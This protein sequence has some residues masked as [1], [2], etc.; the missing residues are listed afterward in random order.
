M[1]PQNSNTIISDKKIDK[2]YLQEDDDDDIVLVSSTRERWEKLHG[3]EGSYKNE[4]EG[5]GVF[6]DAGDEDD[7]LVVALKPTPKRQGNAS[8]ND[9][10]E[11]S[12]FHPLFAF[13]C[14]VLSIW[15]ILRFWRG[16]R[17]APTTK[18]KAVTNA[19][20]T[21]LSTTTPIAIESEETAAD[22]TNNNTDREGG[23]AMKISSAQEKTKSPVL[24]TALPR[25]PVPKT[26]SSSNNQQ[27]TGSTVIEKRNETRALAQQFARDV[28]L[29]QEVLA[30]HSLDPSIAPQLAMSLQ[31][32]QQIIESQRELSYQ[33]AM[34]DAHQRSF[35]R[36]RSEE[37]HRESLIGGRYDPDW[38]EK[39]QCLRDQSYYWNSSNGSI[40]RL[41]WEVLSIQQL[42]PVVVPT[43]QR[44]FYQERDEMGLATASILRDTLVSVL[45]RVCEC[46]SSRTTTNQFAFE[47]AATTISSYY[48]VLT[49]FLHRVLPSMPFEHWTCYGHCAI[50]ASTL[51]F[52]AILC[53]QGLRMLSLPPFLHHFVNLASMALFYGPQ[54]MLG[55]VF[56]TLMKMVMVVPDHGNDLGDI[57]EWE[58]PSSTRSARVG[59]SI[60]L[61]SLW[62][63][64]PLWSWKETSALHRDAVRT[65]V[66]ADPVDFEV[67]FR[68]ARSRLEQWY[69]KQMVMRYLLLSVYSALVLWENSN[70]RRS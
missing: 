29:V 49:S 34:L 4:N 51:L 60:L 70:A 52:F 41:W 2:D 53:H 46:E 24:K 62:V 18:E 5:A 39:L 28:K 55:L 6:N 33:T 8:T 25:S 47:S 23:D 11:D 35:D 48:F 63:V 17:L 61:L 44:Y 57:E 66:S 40:S 20:T 69:R 30:E 32:S 3:I 26:L 64:L 15:V 56:A 67:S 27:A 12:F 22:N 16:S 50:L 19:T 14:I 1:H 9:W 38:N 54:R 45:A 13:C 31:S 10:R 65:V 43:W 36:K 59:C 7:I 42:A 68:K 58:Q 37:R 21:D